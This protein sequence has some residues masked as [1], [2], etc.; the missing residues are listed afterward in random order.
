MKLFD[1]LSQ[2]PC[3]DMLTWKLAPGPLSHPD[4]N[5]DDVWVVTTLV[6]FA[7][8]GLV[9]FTAV[10]AWN[11]CLQQRTVTAQPRAASLSPFLMGHSCL[12]PQG[13]LGP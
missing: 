1:T 11:S 12:A 8:A 2:L 6:G 7:L 9:G 10:H 5:D 3:P 13:C 4:A